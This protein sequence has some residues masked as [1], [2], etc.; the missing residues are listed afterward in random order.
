MGT[1]PGERLGSIPGRGRPGRARVPMFVPFTQDPVQARARPP[2]CSC[3]R[4]GRRCR[5]TGLGCRVARGPRGAC[6]GCGE[7]GRRRRRH[8]SGRPT[9]ARRG[10]RTEGTR[11]DRGAGPMARRPDAPRSRQR[12]DGGLS[13]LGRDGSPSCRRAGGGSRAL[14]S[15]LG[16]CGNVNRGVAP[17]AARRNR[18][19]APARRGICALG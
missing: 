7:P 3:R 4:T 2:L 11:R 8:R 15:R 9:E 6:T 13:I 19:S 12:A 17:P 1:L 16:W 18:A 10:T 14:R 5:T